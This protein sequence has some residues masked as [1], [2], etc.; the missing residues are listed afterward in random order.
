MKLT[1]RDYFIMQEISRWRFLLSRHICVFCGFT[2][3]R[4]CNRRLKIL[5][6][7]GYIKKQHLFYG[8]P[9]LYTLTYKGKVLIG[10]NT[11]AENIRLEQVPHD[12]MAL[13]TV[14]YL[15]QKRE[16]SLHSF[17]SEKQLHQRDGFSNRKHRPDFIFTQNDKTYC[18]EIELS[19][20]SKDR[21]LKNLKDNFSNYDGQIWIIPKS[22]K[23]TCALI[24]GSGYPNIEIMESEVILHSKEKY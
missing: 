3:E 1:E 10:T 4:A 16:L 18:V 7:H 13:D 17:V 23:R 2:G 24:R 19:I 20:K 15:M 12:V 21:F 6:D 9:A 14:V 11:K 8:M 22:D 5:I